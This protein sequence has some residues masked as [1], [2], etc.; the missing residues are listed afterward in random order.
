M[1][2]RRCLPWLLGAYHKE[3]SPPPNRFC[4]SLSPSIDP[5]S[6]DQRITNLHKGSRRSLVCCSAWT[7]VPLAL[8]YHL[9]IHCCGR[10]NCFLGSIGVFQVSEAPLI[11]HRRTQEKAMNEL[12]PASV[13][14]CPIHS[15][16]WT[17]QGELL[18]GGVDGGCGA[19]GGVRVNELQVCPYILREV[20]RP[21]FFF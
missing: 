13:L 10:R 5:T 8:H 7:R 14:S 21:P 2:M 3:P 20:P 6:I 17:G 18:T 16:W 12:N 1:V 15:S 11:I 19:E 4:S 9:V